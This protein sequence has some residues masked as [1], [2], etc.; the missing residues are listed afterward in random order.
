MVQ[1]E[2]KAIQMGRLLPGVCGLSFFKKYFKKYFVIMSWVNVMLF[3]LL[4]FPL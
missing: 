4:G 2:L 3:I 1:M